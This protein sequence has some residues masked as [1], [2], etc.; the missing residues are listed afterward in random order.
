[1]FILLAI[2]AAAGII[3]VFSEIGCIPAGGG[4]AGTAFGLLLPV[5]WHSVQD[6]TDTTP[7]ESSQ[8]K[9]ERAEELKKNSL[10]RIS[11]AYLYRIKAGDKY[12]LVLNARHTGKYQ[13]VGGV[14]KLH[15]SESTELKNR[16]HIIDDDKIPIDK[17]SKD[18]YRLQMENRYL[19]KFILRFDHKADRERISDLG[20]EF[21][22]E[23]IDTGILNWSK[24]TYRVCGRHMTKL[25]FGEHFQIYELLLADVV[26]LIP[27]PSQENDLNKLLQNHDSQLLFADDKLIESRGVDTSTGDLT[28]T[29]ASHTFKILQET[30]SSLMKLPESGRTYTVNL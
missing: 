23:L 10:V 25:E 11:F 30:E 22:E 13:P 20:R 3:I 15:G 27:T 7:W 28:E 24:I 1:M 18:D 19:R 21:R 26:E 14:Y 2:T 5:L 6:I 8:R 12:L 16:Y 29:I 4:I 17:S 9:L